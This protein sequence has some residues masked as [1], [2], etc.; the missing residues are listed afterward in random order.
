MARVHIQTSQ[1]QHPP[2]NENT[3]DLLA[4]L[5][6]IA[7]AGNDPKLDDVEARRIMH[8]LAFNATGGEPDNVG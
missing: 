4:I 3:N 5:R 8:D 7:E 1:I 2:M 6:K